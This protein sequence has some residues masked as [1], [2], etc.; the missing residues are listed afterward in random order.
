V[1]VRPLRPKAALEAR[2]V[3]GGWGRAD[4]AVDV[5]L[6]LGPGERVAL[7]GPNGAGKTTL[8]DLLSGRLR[9][10]GGSVQLGGV[11]VSREGLPR[12]ARRGLGYVAQEPTVFRDLSVRANLAVA[13]RAP[14]RRGPPGQ[15]EEVDAALESWGLTAIADRSA[16]VLSGGE[17][18][19]VEIARAL[20]TNP[21]V[22]LL[23]EPFAG[24]DPAARRV[25]ARALEALPASVTLLISDHAAR[26]VLDVVARVVLLEDGRVAH[27]GPRAGFEAHPHAAPY[28]GA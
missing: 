18:R 25:L 22:V 15:P 21:S 12:R 7:L 3:R 1:T 14:A 26:E 19:R 9:P 10:R 28:F 8:F 5:D 11:D 2:A 17:R 20:L 6:R 23:D 24:L 16:A 4:A 27:D 13:L